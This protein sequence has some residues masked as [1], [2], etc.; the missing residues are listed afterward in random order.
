LGY[1]VSAV[2]GGEEAIEYLRTNSVDLL[3]LDMIMAPNMDGLEAYRKIIEMHPGQKAVIAS[4]YSETESVREAQ[5]LGA[6]VYIK[7]PYTL[8]KIG[9]AVRKELD[10]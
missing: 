2:A 8:E 1:H 9:I 7:K 10:K 6:G 4:G 3:V 5:R